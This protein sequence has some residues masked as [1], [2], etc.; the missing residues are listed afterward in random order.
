[1]VNRVSESLRTVVPV[2]TLV[3][4]CTSALAHAV[5]VEARLI[6]PAGSEIELKATQSLEVRALSAPLHQPV[7]KGAM[8]VEMDVTKLQKELDGQ[9]KTLA[10]AQAERRQL[11]SERGATSSTPASNSRADMQNA[12]AVNEA[13]MAE[14]SAISDL[15]RLQSELATAD[16]RAPA[17][18]YLT[19]HLFAVGAKAKKRKPLAAFVEAQKTVLEATVPA[20]EAAAFT[21][22][23]TVRVAD[24]GNPAKSFRG[25]V[26][27]VT[28]GGEA[29]ALRIQPLELPFL[30]LEAPAAV[31]LS[32]V[33]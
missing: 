28:A 20:P 3:A 11:A 9:Q 16:L 22:G 17:D 19:R 1:M 18:G 29:V 10:R 23:A 6:A 33:P 15:A 27:S 31:T 14:A 30:A 7:A 25:K 8:L 24:A 32:A 5:A 2:A 26:L 21:A 13:Q 4:L 12:S